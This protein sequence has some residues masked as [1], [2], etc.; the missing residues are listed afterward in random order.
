MQP[1]LLSSISRNE[2]RHIIYDWSFSAYPGNS[3]CK[4]ADDVSPDQVAMVKSP[5]QS[6][7]AGDARRFRL[8]LAEQERNGW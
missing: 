8:K 3:A 6:G 4:I 7:L 1:D 2:T 5:G